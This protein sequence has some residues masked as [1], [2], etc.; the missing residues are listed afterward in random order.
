MLLIKKFKSKFLG[1]K[2]YEC[3]KACIKKKNF[4]NVLCHGDFFLS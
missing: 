4:K 3:K 1:K 2:Y